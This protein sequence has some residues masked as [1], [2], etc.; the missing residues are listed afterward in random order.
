[1]KNYLRRILLLAAIGTSITTSAQDARWGYQLSFDGSNDYFTANTVSAAVTGGSWTMEFWFRSTRSVT[2][3]ESILAFNPSDGTNRIEIGVGPS[4]GNKMYIYSPN[5]SPTTLYGTTAISTN[6]WCHVA[7]TYNN[8]N[9]VIQLYLNG[10]ATAEVNRTLPA[11]DVVQN[12]DRFSLGQEWDNA[13][14]SGFFAG[15][16]DEVRVWNGI[17]SNTQIIDDRYREVPVNSMGLLAY[18]KMTNN[19]GTSVT[20]NTGNSRTGTLVNGPAWQASTVTKSSNGSLPA[21]QSINKGTQPTDIIITNIPYANIQWQQSP[22]NA[23]WGNIST[24][25]AAT[26]SGLQMGTL[27]ETS[28]YRAR[29]DNG[30]GTY[31]YSDVVT[32]TVLAGTL[33]VHWLGFSAQ[34]QQPGVLLHWSTATEERSKYFEVEHS[35]D[36]S[37]W[38]RIG[39]RTAAGNSTAVQQYEFM[40][41]NPAKGV[42]YYRIK[43]IDADGNYTYSKVILISVAGSRSSVLIYPNPVANG[44]V[45]IKLDEAAVVR[46]INTYGNTVL[47]KNLAA[48]LHA[49]SVQHLPRGSYWVNAGASVTKILV[50]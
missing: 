17:R 36:A 43:E 13:S 18:Y 25:T 47:Q 46:I 14:A 4:A 3:T 12:T 44:V 26:L 31:D 19:S 22:D 5:S 15:Q 33:P 23:A 16:L 49:I 40:H 27:N 7:V 6:T 38:S 8:S 50:Q 39:T 45:Y 21:D 1:M 41:T 35:T 11:A 2:Y 9:R 10:N 29:L 28:Y 20:D 34:Q 42:N 32:V 37:E 30:Y 24:A 48:G